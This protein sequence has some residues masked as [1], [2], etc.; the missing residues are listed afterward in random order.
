MYVLFSA[1]PTLFKTRS[2]RTELSTRAMHTLCSTGPHSEQELAHIRC[3]CVA[4]S[5]TMKG[6]HA[7]PPAHGRQQAQAELAETHT[8]LSAQRW[9]V[10]RQPQQAAGFLSATARPPLMNDSGVKAMIKSVLEA[11]SGDDRALGRAD[12]RRVQAQNE[13]FGRT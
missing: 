12:T 9:R 7:T 11:H 4:G 1:A 13:A 10:R 3:F 5:G 8:D 6:A 2:P